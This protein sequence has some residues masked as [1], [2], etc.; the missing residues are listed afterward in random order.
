MDDERPGSTG[1]TALSASSDASSGVSVLDG[2]GLVAGAAVASVHLRALLEASVC[3]PGWVIGWGCFVW[4]TLTSSGPFIYAL[5]RAT[6]TP[7][8]PP[9]IGERLWAMIGVPWLLTALGLSISSGSIADDYW[10]GLG[11]AVGLAVVSMVAVGVV[12]VNWVIVDPDRAARTFSPPW[13]NRFGLF[14][15]IAW[16]V[17]WGVG[18]AVVGSIT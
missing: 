11:L 7:E 14:L 15:A 5:R 17:Q 10:V 2:V 1:D 4:I 9:L 6:G 8:R 16:P 12:W 13:T 3:G 18:M